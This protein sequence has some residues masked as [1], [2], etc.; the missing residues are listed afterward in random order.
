MIF[1]PSRSLP[2]TI[3]LTW[4][5]SVTAGP[6]AISLFQT[7]DFQNGNP[8]WG[9]GAVHPAPPIVVNNLGPA[10]T[11]DHALQI[12]ASGGSGPG[13]RVGLFSRAMN[14]TGDYAGT[15]IN[16]IEVDLRNIGISPQ[17][18]NLNLF[19][20]VN[21][22][23]G[24]FLTQPAAVDKFQGW[25]SHRFDLTPGSLTAGPGSTDVDATL[26][27]VSEIRVFHS[28]TG[29]SHRGTSVQ[30]GLRID[31]IT[32]VPEPSTAALL[33]ISL[34]FLRNRKP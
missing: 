14:W 28:S 10:G 17:D 4:F 24:W 2:G 34:V 20:A 29:T 25:G 5:L 8:D 22:P 18:Q 12:G 9:V 15:G 33:L 31:N 16:A 11:G 26:G 3:L 32:A 1:H 19:F 27:N 7:E 6:A 13:S 30:G 21:G 23:G